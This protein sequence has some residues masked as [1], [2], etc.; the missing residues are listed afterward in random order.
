MIR[1]NVTSSDIHF[2][3]GSRSFYPRAICS[4]IAIIISFHVVL[5]Q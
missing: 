2:N 3:V 5:A 4:V 1:F